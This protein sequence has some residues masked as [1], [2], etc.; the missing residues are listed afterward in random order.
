VPSEVINAAEGICRRIVA[1]DSAISAAYQRHEIATAKGFRLIFPPP[2]PGEIGALV[3]E[4]NAGDASRMRETLIRNGLIS[5]KSSLAAADSPSRSGDDAEADT[6]FT[7]TVSEPSSAAADRSREELVKEASYESKFEDDEGAPTGAAEA[8]IDDSEDSDEDDDGAGD[9]DDDD[10][11]AEG[12]TK[13]SA[14]STPVNKARVVAA[15]II[16]GTPMPYFPPWDATCEEFTKRIQLYAIF[17]AVADELYSNEDRTGPIS[18]KRAM[19]NSAASAALIA[20]AVKLAGETSSGTAVATPRS[21]SQAPKSR[22]PSARTRGKAESEESGRLESITRMLQAFATAR[23]TSGKRSAGTDAACSPTHIPGSSP[24]EKKV[25]MLS[26]IR[27]DGSRTTSPIKAPPQPMR[28]STPAISTPYSIDSAQ[29]TPVPVSSRAGIAASPRRPMVVRREASVPAFLRPKTASIPQVPATIEYTG[30]GMS[31]VVAMGL[32]EYPMSVSAVLS[33]SRRLQMSGV[34]PLPTMHSQTITLDNRTSTPSRRV[35]TL[36]TKSSP[37]R[38]PLAYESQ[39]F[40]T[41]VPA[42]VQPFSLAVEGAGR[43][44]STPQRAEAPIKAFPVTPL[45][46]GTAESTTTLKSLQRPGS[47]ASVSRPPSATTRLSRPTSPISKEAK[48]QAFSAEKSF[49]AA[50]RAY[51]AASRP[52]RPSSASDSRSV[53]AAREALAASAPGIESPRLARLSLTQLST[54]G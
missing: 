44:K 49:D 17:Q 42:Q 30:R 40:S 34:S 15:P 13:T 21:I 36:C 45:R 12:P 50:L 37:L 48:A 43:A 41:M 25:I 31:T 18:G 5:P 28:L 9:G 7:V 11:A 54:H 20:A 22:P 35:Q 46:L 38:P 47:S 29:P 24:S 16:D 33:S 14:G 10:V 3:W 51:A 53:A 8:K 26:G 27:A 32:G 19:E 23:E 4:R 52:K 39:A 6:G 1:A 2:T